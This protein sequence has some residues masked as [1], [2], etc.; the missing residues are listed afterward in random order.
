MKYI[1]IDIGSSFIK[2][3]LL[4][5]DNCS[6]IEEKKIPSPP[7]NLNPGLNIF[8]VFAAR[9]VEIVRDL[10]DSFTASYH[11]INGVL[12]ATQM[13]GFVYVTESK[14]DVYISWQDMRCLNLRKDG[15][16][17]YMAYLQ[18]LFSPKDMEKCGVYIKPSLGLCNLYTTLAN[19]QTLIRNGELFT[20]GSYIIA[21]LTGNNICHIMNAAPL[22]LV[23]VENR[24]WAE[25][26]IEK[27]GLGEIKLPQLAQSDFEICG[28]FPSN[29]CNLAV[30][31]D[32]GDQQ[33][34]ILGSM[35]GKNDALINIATGSQVSINVRD[36][37]PGNY[38]VRPFFE[39]TYINTISNMPAGRGLD[40]LVRFL[41]EAVGKITGSSVDSSQ[42]WAVIHK[43][44]TFDSK[45]INVN[46]GFYATP[47][48]LNGGSISGIM[49]FN[50]SMNSLFSASFEDMAK[51]YW[52]HIQRLNDPEK[53]DKLVCAGGV[54]WK[55]PEL[56]ETIA[57][58][59]GKR[60]VLSIISDESLS[61][62]FRV[63]LVCDGV[64][65]NLSDKPELILKIL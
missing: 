32:Y 19:D 5:T 33:V 46:M 52:K 31:P 61:G 48:N 25:S 2:S 39:N 59:S 9:Y 22:G 20:I 34:S 55:T 37:H 60:C 42:I 7:K 24:C 15:D 8:E 51:T 29:G 44:Y 47:D 40:V 21:N 30:Y 27:A 35:A 65:S 13:H 58:I 63:A 4:E 14:E 56:V 3:V 11:D 45:G 41:S 64:C 26:I 54:S 6:I 43:D 28:Y 17:S 57:K 36:F 53:I 10:I 18:E 50:F 62:L 12:F 16:I 23:N 1:S 49:P 38:E